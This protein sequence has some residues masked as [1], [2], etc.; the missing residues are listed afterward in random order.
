M[1]SEKEQRTAIARM[2]Y[3][4]SATARF[5]SLQAKNDQNEE[6]ANALPEM[7]RLLLEYENLI[8]V[9]EDQPHPKALAASASSR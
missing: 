4:I 9:R 7:R 8:G 1:M 3:V 6:L 5:Y 2:L